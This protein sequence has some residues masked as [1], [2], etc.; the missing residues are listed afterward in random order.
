MI[1]FSLQFPITQKT[2]EQ[3]EKFSNSTIYHSQRWHEF[4]EKALG[5]KVSAILGYNH[6]EEFIWFLPFI[7]KRTLRGRKKQIS[8]PLSHYVTAAFDRNKK[9]NFEQTNLPLFLEKKKLTNFEIHGP[10]EGLQEKHYNDITVLDLENFASLE[11]FYQSFDYKSIRYMINR[12]KKNNVEIIEG[13]E[14]EHFEEF[15]SLL[16]ETRHRQGAPIYP[17]N[18]FSWMREVFKETDSI[19]LLLGYYEK[20]LV[21]GSIFFYYKEEATYGYSASVNNKAVKKLGA[22]ELLLWK[23]MEKAYEKQMKVFDFGTTPCHL[24]QLKRYKE[25]WGSQSTALPYSFYCQRE[26]GNTINRD[27]F[28]VKMVESVL[29]KLPRPLFIQLSP[30]LLKIAL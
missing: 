1:K 20:K 10:I 22:N 12:A 5:W 27:G 2:Y 24:P 15:Y 9:E 7:Q 3:V 14:K 4:M 8:L 17:R 29:R 25:K 30:Q 21:S 13:K 28:I 26:K 6:L 16:A 19:S 11:E 18:Y 23:G